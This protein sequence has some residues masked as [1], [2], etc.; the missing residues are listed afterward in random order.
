ML[1]C[2]KNQAM[3]AAFSEEPGMPTAIHSVGLFCLIG[4]LSIVWGCA[5]ESKE[6]RIKNISNWKY[7]VCFHKIHGITHFLIAIRRYD[8]FV[9]L[10]FN[11]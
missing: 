6:L 10:I 3:K 5:T 4:C 2:L 8:G 1:Q 11:E 7:M 9:A